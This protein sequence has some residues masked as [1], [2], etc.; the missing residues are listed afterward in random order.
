M[1][2]SPKVDNEQI[3]ILFFI[4]TGNTSLH[5]VFILSFHS[6]S[7]TII[8]WC[9]CLNEFEPLV[10]I[11]KRIIFSSKTNKRIVYLRSYNKI[12][13]KTWCGVHTQ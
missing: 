9:T 3:I 13:L 11:D 10:W 1:T 12:F 8:S 2:A 4:D 6:I 7:N 5:L